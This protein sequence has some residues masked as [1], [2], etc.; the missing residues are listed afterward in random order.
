MGPMNTSP[1][2]P[3]ASAPML[4]WGMMGAGVGLAAGSL[5][6]GSVSALAGHFAR[7]VVTPARVLGED[8]AV[9]AVVTTA[10]GTEVILP[11]NGETTV[12]GTYS[13]FFDAGRGHAR[14]GAITSFTPAEGTIARRVEHVYSG[15]LA[16]AVRGR[17]SG[18]VYGEPADI[19]VQAREVLVPVEGGAAPAWL[20]PGSHRARTWAIMVHGRGAN[21]AEGIR[22]LPT[23]Q[24]LGMSSLLVSYRNDGQAPDAT[25]QRYGLGS[26]EWRDVESA[27]DYAVEQGA[28]DVVLFGWSMGGAIALQV[29]DRSRHRRRLQALVLDGPVVN[30]MD[31]LRHHARVNRIPE[32]VGRLGQWMLAHRGGRWV[33]GLASPV[34]LKDLNWVARA[35]HLRVPTLI[36]HS[37][38]DDFVPVGPSAE[39]AE[40]NPAFVTFERFTQAKHTRE[41]NVDP[42]H[43]SGT[44]AAWLGPVL[45]A[46]H[47]G[48]MPDA[49]GAAR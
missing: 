16:A 43:W 17:W 6:A 4:R 11:A 45:D 44:V 22:A 46:P 42:G 47:P 40:L 34:N 20:V 13:L 35:D 12:P 38:D 21:R 49:V 10:D 24:G 37:E 23:V 7:Q 15:N 32:P 5:L 28:R 9:L 2:P 39:L 27:I 26:T 36:L 18:V 1:R 41:W 25:D 33:T 14:I 30:W 8:L 31:V 29:A 48:S 19:D 3:L